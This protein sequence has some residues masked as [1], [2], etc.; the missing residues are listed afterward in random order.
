MQ[1][2]SL[3]T[4]LWPGLP[5]LWWRGDFR[6]LLTAVSFAI[7]VNFALTASFIWPE[8]LSPSLVGLGWIG[9]LGFWGVAAWLGFRELDALRKP[10]LDTKQQDLFARAQTEYL[11]EHWIEAESA[12]LRLIERSQ[13]DVDAHLMLASLCRRTDRQEEALEYLQTLQNM[14]GGQKWTLEVERERNLIA[15]S[16]DDQVPEAISE[17]ES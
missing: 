10:L 1:A 16:I 17:T 8:M 12:L 15:Q 14:E 5:R 3:I 4:C 2:S 9:L 7:A 11:N 6:S 13:W